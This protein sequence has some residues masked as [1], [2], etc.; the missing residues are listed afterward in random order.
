MEQTTNGT[1]IEQADVQYRRALCGIREFFRALNELD[2][3]KDLQFMHW[4]HSMIDDASA[5]E[6]EIMWSYERFIR[7]YQPVRAAQLGYMPTV[8][9]LLDEELLPG[10]TKT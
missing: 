7:A 1:A 4:P 3:I 8:A 9:E 6:M 5:V 2:K 10:E